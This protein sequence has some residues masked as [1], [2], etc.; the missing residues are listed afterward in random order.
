MSHKTIYIDIDEEITSIVDRVRKALADE[1]IVVVPKRAILIQSLVNLKLL[2][3]EASRRNKRLMIVTQDRIGKKLIEKAGILVQGKIDDTLAEDEIFDENP[4]KVEPEIPRE[5]SEGEEDVF[6]SSDYF[7]EPLPAPVSKKGNN[8]GKISFEKKQAESASKSEPRE[9]KKTGKIAKIKG[10]KEEKEKQ[11]RISD[12]VAGPMGKKETRPKLEKPLAEKKGKKSS[13]GGYF[14]AREMERQK[15]LEAEKFFQASN[16]TPPSF[17]RREE[18]MLKTTRVKGRSGKYFVVFLVAFFVFGIAAGAY[19]FLPRATIVLHLRTEEK[20]VSLAIEASTQTSGIDEEKKNIPAALEQITK[21]KS[22]EF[23]ST[24]SQSDAGKAAGKVVIYNEFS[25]DSQPLVATTRLETD[26][27]KIFRITK[28]VVVPG[29]TDVGG[30]MKPGAIEVD[31]VADKPG[32][33]Y[34]IGPTSFKVPGFKGGSKYEKFHAESAKAMEGGSKGEG[35]AVTSEDIAGAKEKLVAEAKK[36][37]LADLKA[38]L[39]DGRFFFEDTALFDVVNAS[40]SESIGSQAQKFTYTVS[41]KGRVLSFQQEDVKELVRRDE[42]AKGA[43]LAQIDFGKGI[44]Y[45]LSESDVEKGFLKFEAKA[46]FDSAVPV[47]LSNFKKDALGKNNGELESLIKKFPAVKS[48]DVN[49]WPFFVN[50]VPMS[51]NRVKIE[52]Q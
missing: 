38:R 16:F 26:D 2:K 3:K 51:E 7:D 25:S 40:S 28:G 11:V 46:D 10:L 39:G 31:V 23:E 30:E 41:V 33:E 49:F 21:E 34:N 48:A 4:R 50:R 12:I 32:E 27:G 24:G 36:E 14:Q 19:F 35:L 43:G 22:G 15:G 8:I 9:I 45:I 37:A 13:G 17:S 5:L 6:G 44:N 42:K 20:S 29:F 18:K 1:V 52:V 47:D